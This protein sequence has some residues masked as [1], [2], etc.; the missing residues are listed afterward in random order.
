MQI[1][2]GKDTETKPGLQAFE[3]LYRIRLEAIPL[4][5]YRTFGPRKH[6]F[7]LGAH[8]RKLNISM[9]I[10][11]SKG[12]RSRC[13]WR[14]HQSSADHVS[15]ASSPNGINGSLIYRSNSSKTSV[16]QMRLRAIH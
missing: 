6:S 8:S 7:G 10:L 9:A 13:S 14:V 16:W 4:V 2:L 12:R 11:D 1:G 5:R 15:A 3:L